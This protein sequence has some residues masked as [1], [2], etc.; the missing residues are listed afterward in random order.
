M[1]TAAAKSATEAYPRGRLGERHRAEGLA[2]RTEVARIEH[3]GERHRH[4][5]RQQGARRRA[6][7]EREVAV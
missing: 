6:P 3:A 4:R 1:N 7:A 2:D 5:E